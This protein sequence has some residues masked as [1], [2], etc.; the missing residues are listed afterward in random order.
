M[1]V[2]KILAGILS[3]TFIGSFAA[4]I[5]AA[6]E[7]PAYINVVDY[8][9]KGDGVTDDQKAIEAAINAAQQLGVP[10]YVPPGTYIHTGY[11][12]LD[13]IKMF[14]AEYGVSKLVG[15]SYIPEGVQIT[16]ENPGIYNMVLEGS[17]G[18]RNAYSRA[19]GVWVWE[20]VNPVVANC[21][22]SR[23]TN[24]GILGHGMKNGLYANNNISY[25]RADGTINMYGRGKTGVE[26]L[27]VRNNFVW[28]TGDD[29]IAFTSYDFWGG[30]DGM[31]QASGVDCHDNVAI[32]YSR[33]ITINGGREMKVYNNY[34]SGGGMGICIGADLSWKSTQCHD[35][36]VFNN[37]VK[38]TVHSAPNFGG[39]LGIRNDRG[40]D[41]ITDTSYNLSFHDNDIYNP[42]VEAIL[43]YG[44][45]PI[46]AEFKN[47]N[48]YIDKEKAVFY[49]KNSPI[50]RTDIDFEGNSVYDLAD[51]P[52]DKYVP[53]VGPDYG[54]DWGLPETNENIA[55]VSE[56]SEGG[57]I[58]AVLTDGKNSEENIWKTDSDS[59]VIEITAG[60]DFNTLILEDN[61]HSISWFKLEKLADGEW[62]Q[63]GEAVRNYGVKRIDTTYPVKAGEK[64][65][66]TAEGTDVTIDELVM[67]YDRTLREDIAD[68]VM[69][70]ADKTMVARGIDF[71]VDVK[72]EKTDLT[73]A[74][75]AAELPG[76][77]NTDWGLVNRNE[78]VVWSEN[79]NEITDAHSGEYSITVHNE[80]NVSVYKVPCYVIKNGVIIA[81]QEFDVTVTEDIDALIYPVASDDGLALE[82][83]ITN[84]TMN[85]FD[86]AKVIIENGNGIF[87]N[88]AEYKL[89][90]V[91]ALSTNIV[92]IVPENIPPE[93][94]EVKFKIE[95]GEDKTIEVS[96]PVN[97]F[98]ADFAE[99]AP[100]I[101]GRLSENEWDTSAGFRVD[102]NT[103]T[104][105]YGIADWAG[106]SDLSVEGFAKWDEKNV[107]FA[108][109]VEDDVHSQPYEGDQL[110]AGDSV[111]L[112]FDSARYN[113]GMYKSPGSEGY[114]ELGVALY[115]DKVTT[116]AYS[117]P[118][119]DREGAA[120]SGKFA[121][122]RD[123][124]YTYYE[125]A[126]PWNELLPE[127]KTAS[128]G[129]VFGF[130]MLVNEND[131]EARDGFM[132]YAD[133]IGELKLPVKYGDLLL[134]GG[135]HIVSAPTV[136]QNDMQ[137][138]D[139]TFELFVSGFRKRYTTAQPFVKNDIFYIPG[140]DF[141]NEAGIKYEWSTDR[142]KI[143][144]GGK[145]IEFVP[146]TGNIIVDKVVQEGCFAPI[147]VKDRIMLTP[148]SLNVLG[149]NVFYEQDINRLHVY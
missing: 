117:L 12:S 15:H 53:K 40:F 91:E 55:N 72:S 108:F 149:Y 89:D 142:L 102:K 131:G 73:E 22:I 104:Q 6:E 70:T 105:M 66:I 16:G 41:G 90:T 76:S 62:Q 128:N 11:F 87:K 130:S 68:D 9:A 29:C 75:L 100:D 139:K 20:A 39:G 45:H 114:T 60:K 118:D 135:E 69:I 47:N 31:Y 13:G 120:A 58:K 85:E 37:V 52:G 134:C 112:A 8:G 50:D 115:Q 125:M 88:G 111:Q 43:V 42:L 30:A 116:A 32:G 74:T 141:L 94:T 44:D 86:G 109:K 80:A 25:T 132:R 97:F 36:E 127:Y 113:N 92:R 140:A 126:L 5:F 24:A 56:F 93:V 67:Y 123:G 46:Q 137:A 28:N 138:A 71:E 82:A 144:R 119:E 136:S 3:V 122:K 14:G 23:F 19:S 107:Y 35:I 7:K 21:S 65:R 63:L 34:T 101:D 33:G 48:V 27:E 38:N 18:P 124:N 99:A 81:K 2:K 143:T 103:K 1:K 146:S 54:I 121:V 98:K 61:S 145:N 133:G 64:V 96:K 129:D 17:Y 77:W 4:P 84:N 49:V 83:G 110:W 95:Y 78:A 57:E 59:A 10:V 79:K 148:D 106:T 147:I 51:Y 26:G